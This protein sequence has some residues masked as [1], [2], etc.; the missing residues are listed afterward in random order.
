M[1]PRRQK[2]FRAGR[3]RR[4]QPGSGWTPPI[5]PWIN[6]YYSD[7][8]TGIMTFRMFAAVAASRESAPRL[9]S[10]YV[11]SFRQLSDV[12][13]MAEGGYAPLRGF[14]NEEETRSVCKTMH[15][16]TGEP[17]SIPLVFPIDSQTRQRLRSV[18]EVIL[19]DQGTPAAR[20]LIED[21]F[22][23]DKEMFADRIFRTRD[24]AHPGV[25]W[26]AGAG[27]YS[28][29]GTV[30]LIRGWRP[31]IPGALPIS[32]REIMAMVASRGWKTV[33]GFQTRNPIHRAHEHCTKVALDKVDG[34]LIHP[35]VGR[36]KADDLPV[37]VRLAC[38]EVLVR[39]YYPQDRVLLAGF[40]AWMRYA[41][42]REAIFHAQVRKNCG[43]TH[44]IVGRDHA[45]VGSYYGPFDAQRI[46]SEFRPGE[47][48]IEPLFFD[49]VHYCRACGGMTT[50]KSCQH[51]STE[52]IHLSGREIRRML[53]EGIAPPPEITRPQVADI[54][55]AAAGKGR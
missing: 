49:F 20:L 29:G 22:R 11:A 39:R 21:I 6:L 27:Q 12:Y 35:L 5:R 18:D 8:N 10:A 50:V 1:V 48:G 17:W 33:V 34:L 28:I 30:E 31:D 13:L 42:P 4:S 2:Q 15:L 9:R 16:T 41:G 51:P 23:I 40:P 46:F 19:M 44:F 7:R 54:L 14:L 25:A 38:Y 47:L 24:P 43:M 53:G 32:P 52:H 37:E 26:L 36:T 55:I 45:G 3:L